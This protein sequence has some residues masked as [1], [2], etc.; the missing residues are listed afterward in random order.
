MSR[1]VPFDEEETCDICGKKGAYDFM[2]DYICPE[3]LRKEKV[4]NKE[5]RVQAIEEILNEIHGVKYLEDKEDESFSAEDITTA[6]IL[7][8]NNKVA[9]T[10]IEA[11]LR[12][13]KIK[14]K[15]ILLNADLDFHKTLGTDDIFQEWLTFMA[16]ALTKEIIIVEEE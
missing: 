4:M 8:N 2:G 6:T 14:A 5:Q 15:D 16:K 13:D 3:C 1:D 9:A 7:R 10:A 12:I 11:R